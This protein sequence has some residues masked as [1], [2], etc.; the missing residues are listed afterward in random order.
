MRPSRIISLVCVWALTQVGFA[1]SQVQ[2]PNSERP[3]RTIT[4]RNNGR[5]VKTFEPSQDTTKY[6]T[7]T[8]TGY[9]ET[10]KDAEMDALKNVQPEI[11]EF[12]AA[13]G[14]AHDWN[15]SLNDLRGLVSGEPK[16]V[17]KDLDGVGPVRETKLQLEMTP[18]AY[19]KLVQQDRQNRAMGRISFVAKLM[20]IAVGLLI[21][22][23]GYFKLEDAT[24]GYYTAWLRLAALSFIA[25]IAAGVWFFASVHSVRY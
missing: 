3:R 5:V 8:A 20:A 23:A 22:F 2:E 4:V 6:P 14:I 10:E 9:G 17:V 11:A 16:T 15:P 25:A 18:K 7:W 24:K 13:A 12:L 1:F 21:A 19:R